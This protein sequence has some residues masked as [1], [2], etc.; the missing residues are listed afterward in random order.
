MAERAPKRAMLGLKMTIGDCIETARPWTPG[1]MKEVDEALRAERILTWSELCRRYWRRFATIV[2]RGK[3]V[4]DSEYY[5][6]RGIVS[7]A[8]PPPEQVIILEALLSDYEVT[9]RS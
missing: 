2:E 1:Q 8:S 3:I 9:R 5:L 4:D 7:D 6:V